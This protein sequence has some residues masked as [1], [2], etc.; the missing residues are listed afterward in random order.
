MADQND[1]RLAP[2]FEKLLSA[3]SPREAAAIENE[4]WNGPECGNATVVRPV[5]PPRACAVEQLG[6]GSMRVTWTNDPAS[7]GV[8]IRRNGHW[9]ARLD[10]GPFRALGDSYVD[11]D[12]PSSPV[13]YEL[14]SAGFEFAKTD[15][16]A[17]PVVEP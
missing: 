11:S 9:H 7:I 16:V 4:I 2:L 10:S 8:V 6:D 1:P 3:G 13:R 17:C 14:A 15:F 12:P 5:G